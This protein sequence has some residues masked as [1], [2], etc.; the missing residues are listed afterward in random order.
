MP[1]LRRLSAGALALLVLG[2]RGTAPSPWSGDEAAWDTPIPVIVRNNNWSTV[3]I[4]AVT[5]GTS[6]RLGMVETG[7]TETFTLPRQVVAS[8]DFHLTVDPIGSRVGYATNS[9]ALSPGVRIELTVE[10]D[11]QLSWYVL[12]ED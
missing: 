8:P 2:C 11:L 10:N 4:Y 12:R 7:N 6:V 5:S 3:R 9:I 1:A